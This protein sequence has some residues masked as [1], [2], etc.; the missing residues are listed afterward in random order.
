MVDNDGKFIGAD[1]VALYNEK[2]VEVIYHPFYP[3]KSLS[4]IRYKKEP[5]LQNVMKN[6][7][8]ILKSRTLSEISE[9][10]RDRLNRLPQEYKRF[11][12]PHLYKVGL[13]ERLR[14]ERDRL[15]DEYKK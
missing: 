12:Y 7:I 5:L 10:S 9:Y 4:V 8:R 11:S 1:A 15:F 14:N 3:L 6:G 13:S 2:D